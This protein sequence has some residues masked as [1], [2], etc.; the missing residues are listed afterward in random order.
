MASR[1]P[2][3]LGSAAQ[4]RGQGTPPS[5]GCQQHRGG[6]FLGGTQ[7]SCPLP[8]PH[9]KHHPPSSSSSGPARMAAPGTTL[10]PCHGAH[11]P[12]RRTC[13]QHAVPVRH[14]LQH[15]HLAA[16]LRVRCGPARRPCTTGQPQRARSY[17]QATDSCV[18]VLASRPMQ[19]S[20][21][22][23]KPNLQSAPLPREQ[24]R[25]G[26]SDPPGPPGSSV[27][28]PGQ[29]PRWKTSPAL[30]QRRGGA[31]GND[32]KG[33]SS[34]A[35]TPAG[36]AHLP[37]PPTHRCGPSAGISRR[38]PACKHASEA[39]PPPCPAPPAHSRRCRS[40]CSPPLC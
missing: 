21:M 13:A 38:Q 20:V 4:G 3:C 24:C 33:A 15:H 31:V 8:S 2:S 22:P 40:R 1:S 5:Q 18:E 16:A 39:A 12:H 10:A 35:L 19:A 14:G 23:H 32:A 11:T 26:R 6:C 34:A 27:R 25:H 17:A 7:C 36:C 28:W 9:C 37:M 30:R 29:G